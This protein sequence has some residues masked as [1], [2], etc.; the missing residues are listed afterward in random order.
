MRDDVVEVPVQVNGKLRGRVNV[1]ADSDAAATEA[2]ARQ[3][4]KLAELI[5]GK[6]IVKVV[7]VPSKLVN[8]VLK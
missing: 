7:V 3:D 4:P 2:A 8:F 1:P 6:T 5:A